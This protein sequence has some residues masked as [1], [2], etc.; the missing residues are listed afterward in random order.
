[1]NDNA[2]STT[3]ADLIIA[4]T[5]LGADALDYPTTRHRIDLTIIRAELIGSNTCSAAG[6]TAVGP[7]CSRCADSSS[8]RASTLTRCSRSTGATSSHW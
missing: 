4:D 8:R 3:T 1:M 7:Q 6:M 2:D 5:R